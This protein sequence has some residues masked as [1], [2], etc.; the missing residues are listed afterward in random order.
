MKYNDFEF[1]NDSLDSII[2][3]SEIC[4]ALGIGSPQSSSSS[5][6]IDIG[7]AQKLFISA[8]RGSVICYISAWLQ[9]PSSNPEVLINDNE[10]PCTVME[11]KIL[12]LML[13]NPNKVFSKRNL[14]ESVTGEDYLSDDNTMNVHMSNLRRKIGKLTEDSYIDTVYGMGY[15]LSK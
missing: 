12:E 15:R 11:Y 13:E 7:R 5:I 4:D 1:E 3:E 2:I 14:F 10:M 9:S 8:E 6:K